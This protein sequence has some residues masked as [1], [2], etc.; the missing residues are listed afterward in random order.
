MHRK[1]LLLSALL[2]LAPPPASA[3]APRPA[4]GALPKGIARVTSV[5]GVTEY[6]L[7]NGLKVLLIPD[8]SIDTITVNVTYLVGSRHE[9]Y[10]ET[11][12]AHLL[13]HLMFRGTRRF[14]DIKA[15]FQQRGAL[16]RQHRVRPDQLLRDFP[17]ERE[18]ARL[19]PGGRGRPH[20]ERPDR[21]EGSRRGDDRGAQR[22]R[23]GGEQRV[24]RAARARRGERL[25]LAQLRTRDHRGAIGHRERPDRAAAG[26]LPALLP[27]GQRGGAGVG[28]A[29]RIDRARARAETLRE[30]SE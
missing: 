26:V 6:R 20:G 25:S 13:E 21:E 8:R 2:L 17:G 3:Q 29:G 7:A 22:V 12:M 28:Q 24:Q 11:G 14:P 15:D 30:D 23:V 27:A 4:A 5:E 9:G 10:G 1:A 16:Q 19:R 18:D